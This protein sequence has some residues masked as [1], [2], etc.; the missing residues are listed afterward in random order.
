[1]PKPFPDKGFMHSLSSLSANRGC[2]LKKLFCLRARTSSNA[3]VNTLY[4]D[5]DY[6]HQLYIHVKKLRSSSC[7]APSLTLFLCL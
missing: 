3:P 7:N 4:T 2:S 5:P 1:M 6:R